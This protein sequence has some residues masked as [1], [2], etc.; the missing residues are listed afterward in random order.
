MSGQLRRDQCRTFKRVVP[1]SGF[2]SSAAL[3]TTAV[4]VTRAVGGVKPVK[5]DTCLT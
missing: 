3:Q 5:D 1:L 2:V 4:R